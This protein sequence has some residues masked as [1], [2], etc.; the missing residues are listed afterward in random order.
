M[1]SRHG[2]NMKYIPDDWTVKQN[3]LK[4]LLSKKETFDNG[5]KLLLE[6]HGLLHDKKVYNNKDRTIYT[7]LWENLK[8]ETC[9]ITSHKETSILWDIWH[10]TRIEDI[11]GNILINNGETIFNEDIRNKL[12]IKIKDTGNA[13]SYKEIQDFNNS[14]NATELKNYRIKVGKSTKKIIENL[15]FNDMKR[16]VEKEQLEKIKRNSGIINDKNSIWLLD[17]WGKKNVF[18]LIMMPIMMPITRHQTVHLNDCFNIKEKY[19]K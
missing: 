14:I 12:N 7:N 19:N 11:T 8:G 4:I 10:I 17:F 15:N 9:K 5:I 3:N 6:M 1:I 18:G 16:K 2:G 13:M